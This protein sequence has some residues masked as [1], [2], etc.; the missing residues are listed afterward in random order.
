MNDK[1][2]QLQTETMKLNIV[3]VFGCN[4]CRR[5]MSRNDVVKRP[6]EDVYRC[7]ACGG[8]VEDKT[9]SETGNSFLQRVGV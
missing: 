9:N 7:T 5:I 1:M 6:S 4:H 2:W 8:V 3:R